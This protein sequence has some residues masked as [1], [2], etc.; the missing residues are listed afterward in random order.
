MERYPLVDLHSERVF[1]FQSLGLGSVSN[2][3]AVTNLLADGERLVVVLSGLLILVQA[4]IGVADVVETMS[5]HRPYR[6]SMGIEKALAEITQNSGT[7]Y[8]PEVVTAC[9]N[10]FSARNFKFPN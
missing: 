4:F 6:P 8:D 2:A 3:F 7:L 10:I 1:Y 9:L 5:S